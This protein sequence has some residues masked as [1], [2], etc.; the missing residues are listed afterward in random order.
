MTATSDTPAYLNIDR[1]NHPAVVA[2]R[3]SREFVASRDKQSWVENFAAEGSVEDPVGPSMFDPEGKGFHGHAEIADFWDK[4]I[5]TT[6]SIEFVF[7]EEI[8]CGN[9]V[10]YIG[11]IVT[12]I[13]GHVSQA[14]GVF[15][16]RADDDGKLVALRAFWEVEATINSVRR[17]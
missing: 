16:Y 4:S 14:R 3:R 2:G 15:T 7:D 12:H 11:K 9:E 6:E 13:A 8:I 17:A 10:A 1:D 5:A